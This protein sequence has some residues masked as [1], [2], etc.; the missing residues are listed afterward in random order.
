M[1]QRPNPARGGRAFSHEH[2]RTRYGH[3]GGVDRLDDGTDIVFGRTLLRKRARFHTTIR[4]ATRIAQVG[5]ARGSRSSRRRTVIGAVA[6]ALV[7][8]GVGAV[9]RSSEEFALWPR[10][11]ADAADT[12]VWSLGHD[13]ADLASLTG[14]P[15]AMEA[16][17]RLGRR[18]V[19]VPAVNAGV[20]SVLRAARGRPISLASFRF[21][22]MAVGCGAGLARYEES[23]HKAALARRRHEVDARCQQAYLAGQNDV[24]MGAD[25]IIDL[26]SRTDPLMVSV[27]RGRT[28]LGE[29][30]G[31]QLAAWKQSLATTTERHAAYL[32]LVL[33]QWQRSR[34][35]ARADL[36]A[37][38]TFDLAEG[39]GT[40]TLTPRQ[41]ATL[42]TVL[43]ALPL[44]GTVPVSPLRPGTIVDPNL[45]IRLT[46]GDQVIEIPPDPHSE[47]TPFDVG[48]L[49]FVTAALWTLDGLLPTGPRA[50]AR[51]VGPLAATEVLLVAWS[52]RLVAREGREAHLRV[53]AMALVAGVLD[54]VAITTSMRETR[55]ADGV[56]FFP[57]SASITPAMLM[58]PLYWCDLSPLQRQLIVGV[59]VATVALG[60][61]LHPDRP[62]LRHVALELLWPLSALISMA[63]VDATFVAEE[64]RLRS[65]TD[66]GDEASI[67]EAFDKGR[68]TVID[69]ATAGYQRTSE[70][71]ARVRGD[72]EPDLVAE[73]GRRLDEVAKRLENL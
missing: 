7:D 34:N 54:C 66:A 33:T 3:N 50:D 30:T 42:M 25:S 13:R 45:A 39:D 14:T 28:A 41:A 62:P 44:R 51:L 69:L 52:H 20:T 10:L 72:L 16:G 46:I 11:V 53:L 29:T 59:L 37:D 4:L 32:G 43:D 19:V 6:S 26:L 24:A 58:L 63:S 23:R 57:A 55:S 71:F 73:I 56:P 67:A 17:V 31:R 40:L 15:L 22:T 1:I 12:A 9:L 36:A 2:S 47:L 70:E 18:G 48:P 5:L 49:G 38:V 8:V 60:V 61:A 35:G 64:R 27:A 68:S 65:R 21:Q